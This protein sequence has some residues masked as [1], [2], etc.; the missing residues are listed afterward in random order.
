[1]PTRCVILET[2]LELQSKAVNLAKALDLPLLTIAHEAEKFDA[3]L[4][5]VSSHLTIQLQ[6]PEKLA[7]IWVDFKKNSLNTRV[8]SHK[9]SQE[10]LYRALGGRKNLNAT[11]LDT[12]AGL[13]R[14]AWLMVNA[15]FNVI[16]L[17]RNPIIYALLQDGLQHLSQMYPEDDAIKRL[18]LIAEDS[19]DYLTRLTQTKNQN[20]TPTAPDI[21]Y[22]DPMYPHRNKTALPQK[23]MRILRALVGDDPDF[24]MLLSLACQAARLR[25][26]VKRPRYAPQLT[27]TSPS[28][29]LTGKSVRFDIYVK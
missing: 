29:Q 17:E 10:L 26:V 6:H 15:G 21:I 8:H 1:M 20:F 24:D 9:I 27:A 19:I 2:H 11:V 25:V 5:Y 12:T 18:Q 23:E 16:M 13:G 4:Q 28:Y 14:D 22:L 3:V 7:P